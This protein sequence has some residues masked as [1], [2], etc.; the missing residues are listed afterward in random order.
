MSALT[1]LKKPLLISGAVHLAFALLLLVNWGSNHIEKE[2]VVVPHIKASVVSEDPNK[3]KKQQQMSEKRKQ[4]EIDRKRKADKERKRVQAEKKKIAD[5]KRKAE[6]KRKAA[7]KKKKDEA[8]ALKRKEESKKK[9]EAERKRLEE[10]K[11]KAEKEK[12]EKIKA[13]KLKAEQEK[14]ELAKQEEELKRLE[15][16]QAKKE[17][18]AEDRRELE[19]LEK[20]L[21]EL[22]Q[23]NAQNAKDKESSNKALDQVIAI[24]QQSVESNW[25]VP[26]G[27]D[28]DSVTVIRFHFQPDGDLR[29]VQTIVSSGNIALDRSV[30]QAAWRMGLVPEI[31]DLKPNELTKL[32]KSYVFKFIPPNLDE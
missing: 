21:A 23:L 11:K 22:E 4:W 13:D 25:K 15:E 18:E 16:E 29:K 31:S 20:E 27:S 10:E 8:L 6:A 5:K 7:E 19:L 17:K 3:Q 2:H 14:E 32:N 26:P 12:A 30:E 24:I 28:T 9:K 1:T